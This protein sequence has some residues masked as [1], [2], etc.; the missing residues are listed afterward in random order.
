MK[1]IPETNFWPHIRLLE[2]FIKA[3]GA[4]PTQKNLKHILLKIMYRSKLGLPWNACAERMHSDVISILIHELEIWDATILLTAILHELSA[5][6]TL[7]SIQVASLFGDDICFMVEMLTVKKFS[8]QGDQP[9]YSQL[10]N[11]FNTTGSPEIRE[12][13]AII[14]I[15][16]MADYLQNLRLLE[17]DNNQ[18]DLLKLRNS[19]TSYLSNYINKFN[20][21]RIPNNHYKLFFTTLDLLLDQIVRSEKVMEPYNPGAVS[22]TPVF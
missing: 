16:I 3:R 13:I 21:Y 10:I 22:L 20:I 12:H 9:F 6:D 14:C 1:T 15:I 7:S 11:T 2:L 18:I 4:S 5:E 8:I 17:V 19:L